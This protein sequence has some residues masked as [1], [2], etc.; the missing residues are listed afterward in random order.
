MRASS[1]SLLCLTV[2]VAACA[3]PA[4]KAPDSAAA[5]AAAPAPPPA[6]I[7]LADIAGTWN[8]T[9]RPAEGTDTTA[10]LSRLT[11]T[12]D[13]SGWTVTLAGQKPVPV[14]VKVDGD[15][16]TLTSEPYNSVRRKGLKVVTVGVHR[17]KGDKLV[18]RTVAHY[19]TT[20]ADSVLV[21]T[22]ESVRAPR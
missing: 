1:L 16:V 12:A 10:T 2:V 15:S 4:D 14:H 11:A 17:L 3:K 9:S 7:N 19:A 21:L 13:T 20:K 5:A 8:T 22:T 18:G 6:T